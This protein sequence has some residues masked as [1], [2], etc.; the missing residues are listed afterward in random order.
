MITTRPVNWLT[1]NSSSPLVRASFLC[2][3]CDGQL[4]WHALFWSFVFVLTINTHKWHSFT[5]WNGFTI[6]LQH[7]R[8]IV[9]LHN[10]PLLWRQYY[11]RLKFCI[12][13]KQ[14]L[15]RIRPTAFSRHGI[16]NAETTCIF[17]ICLTSK[18]L[19]YIVSPSGKTGRCVSMC[20]S[21]CACTEH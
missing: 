9:H 6:L 3:F 16:L 8:S 21:E 11:A 19:T 4:P 12:K 17:E 10:Y 7:T 5:T 14:Y 1:S 20:V 15:Y 18:F 2:T 13:K